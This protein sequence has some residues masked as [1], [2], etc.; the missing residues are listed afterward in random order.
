MFDWFVKCRVYRLELAPSMF[1]GTT[2]ELTGKIKRKYRP[3]ELHFPMVA[4]TLEW[5]QL[6]IIDWIDITPYSPEYT[7]LKELG[8]REAPDLYELIYRIVHEHYRG[9][10]TKSE[11]QLP[12]ALIF[13]AENFRQHYSKSWA[14]ARIKTAFLPSLSP[15]TH[16]SN[17][18]ILSAPDLVF[19]GKSWRV[20]Q[21][22]LNMTLWIFLR[23]GTIMC[24]FVT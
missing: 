10:R 3:N 18:I 1:L 21:S 14:N 22:K 12:R 24:I 8:V 15:E 2:L 17:E 23:T 20:C 7:L 13:F 5:N 9:C 6:P 4:K 11:Y 19:R 16:Q